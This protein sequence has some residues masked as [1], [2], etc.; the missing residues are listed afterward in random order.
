MSGQNLRDLGA[1]QAQHSE[2]A[3]AQAQAA[4][5]AAAGGYKDKDAAV[6]PSGKVSSLSIS[7]PST[8]ETGGAL[9]PGADPSS[10]KG[11]QKPVSASAIVSGSNPGIVSSTA[12]RSLGSFKKLPTKKAPPSAAPG[13]DDVMADASE[14]SSNV[15]P[16]DLLS[17]EEAAQKAAHL[18]RKKAE[19]EKKVKERQAKYI[20]AIDSICE[21]EEAFKALLKKSHID[22]RTLSELRKTEADISLRL[23]YFCFAKANDFNKRM[24]SHFENYWD[25]EMTRSPEEQ[26]PQCKKIMI[27]R[28]V[29]CCQLGARSLKKASTK[30]SEDNNA[31]APET[32]KPSTSG[33]NSNRGRQQNQG[34]KGKSDRSSS[35][36]GKANQG[37]KR[38]RGALGSTG[39]TSDTHAPKASKGSGA[40]PSTSEPGDAGTE[41][42]EKA[43]SYSQ[44]ATKGSLLKHPNALQ[45]QQWKVD[46][47]GDSHLIDIKKEDWELHIRENFLMTVTQLSIVVPTEENPSP[48]CPVFLHKDYNYEDKKVYFVPADEA[49]YKWFTEDYVPCLRINKWF[50]KTVK[51]SETTPM[52]VVFFTIADDDI[53][54]ITKS[55]G[56]TIQQLWPSFCQMNRISPN[57][58]RLKSA[59][60]DKRKKHLREIKFRA[61]K[62]AITL[63][64]SAVAPRQAGQVFWFGSAY[65]LKVKNGIS[66]LACDPDNLNWE[67]RGEGPVSG[68]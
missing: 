59:D 14:S 20:K 50:Y 28:L 27:D 19:R 58:I 38:D 49:T 51:L 64:R 34:N 33:S 37:K 30:D 53:K 22:A 61:T 13:E 44:A 10:S 47:K 67:S 26:N 32:D 63:L 6:P 41:Q 54:S 62:P 12:F 48:F 43:P 11:G 18:E 21:S 7:S 25:L 23:A 5:I 42:Q 2:Q 1:L 4:A 66:I 3:V 24:T 31:K 8:D 56:K 29:D 57:E 9:P 40:G 15:N 68:P 46:A 60:Q 55:L 45:L 17:T 39:S 16:G 65:D 35:K 36:G 52:A